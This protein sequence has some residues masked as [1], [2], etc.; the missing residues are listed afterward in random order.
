MV[1]RS[2]VH[3]GWALPGGM[4]ENGETFSEAFEREIM[5]EVGIKVLETK[6]AMLEAKT[7]VSPSQERFQFLLAVYTGRMQ[8]KNLPELTSEAIKEGLEVV[9]FSPNQIPANMILGDRDKLLA[10]MQRNFP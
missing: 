2:Q 4:V 8:E 6:L 9:L 5:E 3:E 1:R 10:Y 7:F